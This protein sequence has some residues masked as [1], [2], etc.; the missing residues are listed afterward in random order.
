MKKKNIRFERHTVRKS[1]SDA[2]KRGINHRN[3][4]ESNGITTDEQGES[5]NFGIQNEDS[6]LDSNTISDKNIQ[7]ANGK[8]I[9]K[10]KDRIFYK[11]KKN[12][13]ASFKHR[14]YRKELRKH[15]DRLNE[16]ES[17]EKQLL[18]DMDNDV[19]IDKCDIVL[20]DEKVSYEKISKEKSEYLVD[21]STKSSKRNKNNYFKQGEKETTKKSSDLKNQSSQETND[22]NFTN[23]EFTRSKYK[24]E[25]VF[26]KTSKESREK[27]KKKSNNKFKVQKEKLSKLYKKRKSLEKELKNTD[28][29]EPFKGTAIVAGMTGVLNRYLESGKEDNAGVK[30]ATKLTDRVEKLSRGAYHRGKKEKL[31][32]HKKLSKL[33]KKIEKQEKKLFFNKNMEEL[34]KDSKYRKTSKLRQ[35]FKRRQYKS[36]LKLRYKNSFKNRLKRSF[37]DGM[38]FLEHIKVRS[39]KTVFLILIVLGIF[40]MLFQAGSLVLNMGSSMVSNTVS[41]TYLSTE[42][43][44]RDINQEFSFLEQGLQEEMDTV[45]VKR[46]GYDEYIINGKEKI[47]HDVHELLSYITSRY[48]V[49]KDVSEIKNELE[50]LFNKMYD[51]KYKEEIEVRYRT[52][53]SSYVDENG[54]EQTESREEPYDYRKLIVTLEKKEMDSI[55]RGVFEAYPNNLSHYETLL[56]SKG[57]MESIFGSGNLS[58]IINNP[59]FSNPGL[60]FSEESV[61]QVVA[62]AQKHIG[63]RYSFGANGPNNFDCSSFVCWTYTHSGIKNM[64][65]TTAWGIYKNYCNPISKDEAKAGDIIFFKGTYKSGNPISHVGI[66]VGGGYMIHAGDPIKYTSINTPYWREHFYGYGRVK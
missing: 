59:N 10:R 41:T 57:N 22:A 25:S 21:G 34:K 8:F 49:V 12:I 43:T 24:K 51:L 40:F 35:F 32:R 44:L 26:D 37:T 1:V 16:K 52:V 42:S 18:K 33:N 29:K 48:G 4:F 60:E 64:P 61:K 62:E 15:K 47:G 9:K 53:T 56:L 14:K 31:K 23:T 39:R 58:E 55:I 17:Q 20:E 38:K 6:R 27:S 63:K 7:S 46:A 45:R 28:T 65:R 19:A 11:S 5:K 30:A 36:E 3:I 66:Y 50:S 54:Q 13:K 2:N